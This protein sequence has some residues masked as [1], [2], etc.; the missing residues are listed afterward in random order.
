MSNLD[1]LQP[2]NDITTDDDE[3]EGVT[4]QSDPTSSLY[5]HPQPFKEVPSDL[6]TAFSVELLEN[7][8]SAIVQA[9][10]KIYNGA[11]NGIVAKVHITRANPSFTS[12]PF[13]F[14]RPEHFSVLQAGA[15]GNVYY[16]PNGYPLGISGI[17]EI[18]FTR[19]PIYVAAVANGASASAVPTVLSILVEQFQI[20]S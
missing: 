16:C 3:F 11:E 9:P 4:F 14:S 15:T 5:L 2:Y 17:P 10:V 13:L 18:F 12:R 7:I 8:P 20:E 1:Q 6:F 19:A